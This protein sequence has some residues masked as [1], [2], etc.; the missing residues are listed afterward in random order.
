VFQLHYS[1]FQSYSGAKGDQTDQ[2]SIG[3][4][5]AKTPPNKELHTKPVSNSYF[6]IPAGADNHKVTAC[7]KLKED[8]K[9]VT[10]MPHMHLRGKA[11]K[12]E[13]I[14]PDGRKEVLNNVPRYD[15]AWQTVYYAK[16][17]VALPKGTVIQVTGWFDNSKNNKFNPAPDKDVRWGDPTYTEM[18]IGWLDYTIDNQNLKGAS[19]MK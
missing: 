11:M 4:I 12:F 6:K 8:I 16:K 10:F 2:S 1:N 14:Y 18:M 17:P 15:F 3:L 5:F 19:A 13:A 9:L 7:W